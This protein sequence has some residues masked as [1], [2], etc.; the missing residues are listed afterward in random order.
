MGPLG[1]ASMTDGKNF[2]VA[3]VSRD[4]IKEI[5]GESNT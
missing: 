5:T 3:R 2:H 4:H 1:T